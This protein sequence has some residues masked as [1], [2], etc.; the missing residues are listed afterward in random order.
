MIKKISQQERAINIERY[1]LKNKFFFITCIVIVVFLIVTAF[2]QDIVSD[3]QEVTI[4]EISDT[5][6]EN[7]K[8]ENKSFVDEWYDESRKPSK[9]K[10][11]P[12]DVW[13]LGIGGGFCTVMIIRERKKAKE[14]FN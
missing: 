5:V 10:F 3:T 12:I 14:E 6:E 9:W 13:I 2:R 7:E 11:Y 1:I 8:T 4:T